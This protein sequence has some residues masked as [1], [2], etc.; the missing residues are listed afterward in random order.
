MLVQEN[1]ESKMKNSINFVRAF[2]KKTS[3]N[4]KTSA[5]MNSVSNLKSGSDSNKFI[6]VIPKPKKV[7]VSRQ[8]NN[9]HISLSSETFV[10][11]NFNSPER[12][13]AAIGHI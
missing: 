11:K 12:Q 5:N 6:Q 7:F 4:L 8:V 13:K 1:L 3:N 9:K 2:S 10:R